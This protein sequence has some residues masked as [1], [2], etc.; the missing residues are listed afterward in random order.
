MTASKIT[1][2]VDRVAMTFVN[3]ALLACIPAATV[4]VFVHS[5]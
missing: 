5:F 4:A 1:A 3:V 2:I